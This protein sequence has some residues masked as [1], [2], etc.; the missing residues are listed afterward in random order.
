M[1][2]RGSWVLLAVTNQGVVGYVWLVR[3]AGRADGVY[4]EEVAVQAQYRGQGVGTRLLVEAA[5]WMFL[6]DFAWIGVSSLSDAHQAR[7]EAWFLRVGFEPEGG[8]MFGAW[9]SAV[10]LDLAGE[11]E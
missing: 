11:V 8:G 10:G 1:A 4:I 2:R 6:R 7:R 5:Q 9:P 3:A